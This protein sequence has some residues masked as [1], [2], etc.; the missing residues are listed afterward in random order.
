MNKLLISIFDKKA[1]SWSFPAQADNKATALRMFADL[2]S[3]KRN[4]VGQHPEDFDLFIVGSFSVSSG[5]LAVPPSSEHLA[6]G[7]ELVSDE[8]RN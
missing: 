3:D 1:E 4:L 6:N 5:A 7:K 2:V 8:I